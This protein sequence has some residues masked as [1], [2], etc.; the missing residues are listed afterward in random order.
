M[1]RATH[2]FKSFKRSIRG[3]VAMISAVAFPVVLMFGFGAVDY[4]IMSKSVQDLKQAASAAALA[5]VNEAQIAYNAREEDVD[6][7]LLM[8]ETAERI[9][10]S[11]TSGLNFVDVQGVTVTPRQVGNRLT[12]EVSY[13]ATYQPQIMNLVGPQSYNIS[14]SQR[15]IVS[16]ASYI[17]I[18]LAFDVSASM[19]VGATVADQQLM[20]D[21]IGC[22][23]GCHQNNRSLDNSTYG[24]AKRAGATM[25]IDVASEAA[26]RSLQVVQNNM[27]LDQQ[28]SFGI[29]KYGT[30]V[31]TVLEATDSRATNVSQVRQMINDEVFLAEHSFAGSTTEL[32][33]AEIAAS[34]PE[35]GSGRTADDRIQYLVVLTDGVDGYRFLPNS[36]RLWNTP[37]GHGVWAPESGRCPAIRVR[38]INIFFIYTE[39]LTPTM[40]RHTQIFDWI[41]AN[42]NPVIEDKFA[43]CTGSASQ[44]FK[45]STPRQIDAAFSEVMSDISTPLRLY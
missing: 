24:A 19:G 28:V 9:F 2:K 20:Q 8:K 21:R 26:Q 36:K 40:G 13:R 35:S 37:N 12:A 16:S 42:I 25:R 44:V 15:A 45:T 33:V 10:A 1:L 11:R 38:G 7:E 29:Y 3:N 18:N 5:A 23:F 41:D 6:L 4:G 39:Y 14:D 43:G 27:S 32:S 34:L 22:T 17:A 30:N 31:E